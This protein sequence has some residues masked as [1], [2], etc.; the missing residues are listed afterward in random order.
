MFRHVVPFPN[1]KASKATGVGNLC[2]I[3]DCYPPPSL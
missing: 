2:Q 3:S 1:Q